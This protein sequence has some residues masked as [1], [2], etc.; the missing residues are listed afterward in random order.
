[1]NA[2]RRFR[3]ERLGTQVTGVGARVGVYARRVL[4]H[5]A[6]T[7]EPL[8]TQR[9]AVGLHV[10]V[11][12]HVFGEIRLRLGLLGASRE[13]T[14]EVASVR[15]LQF[16][17]FDLEVRLAAEVALVALDRFVVVVPEQVVVEV[18][19]ALERKRAQMT[20]VGALGRVFQNMMADVS[21]PFR[22]EFAVR[23]VTFV[24]FLR[25]VLGLMMVE[26]A[27]VTTPVATLATLERSLVGMFRFVLENSLFLSRGE[28]AEAT[29]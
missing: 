9:A 22:H 23:K 27:T 21:P 19:F 29:L 24:F 14:L 17:T 18:L 8:P 10:A 15:M 26:V 20:G 4:V 12:A 3:L 5:R 6:H 7:L 1:V 25:R 13:L 11:H 16:V 2:E 28:V